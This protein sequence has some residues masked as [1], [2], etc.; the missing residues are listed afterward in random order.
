[1]NTETRVIAFTLSS[2]VGGHT[3]YAT[4]I[5]C[6]LRP[7]VE[8]TRVGC[9]PPVEGLYL[10]DLSKRTTRSKRCSIDALERILVRERHKVPPFGNGCNLLPGSYAR[11]I[12]SPV[13]DRYFLAGFETAARLLNASISRFDLF[14]AHCVHTRCGRLVLLYHAREYPKLSD[15]FKPFLGYCQMDSHC[16]VRAADMHERTV[17]WALGDLFMSALKSARDECGTIYETE[18]GTPIA[19][20]FYFKPECCT[21]AH[22]QTGLHVV[23]FWQEVL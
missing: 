16:E 7:R 5:V 9:V 3:D 13:V 19:D 1:M 20:M 4:G 12:K 17:L 23:P 22:Q 2:S 8:V 11:R 10:R 15:E 6:G 21:H 14:H 18:I